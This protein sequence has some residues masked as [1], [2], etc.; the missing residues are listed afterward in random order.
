MAQNSLFRPFKIL[1]N[2]LNNL[3]INEGQFIITTDTRE[4]Y[5]DVSNNNRIF[6]G[7]AVDDID[8][9]IANYIKG[10]T[11][12]TIA[13]ADFQQ[14]GDYYVVTIQDN[15]IKAGNYV[16]FNVSEATYEIATEAEMQGFTVCDVGYFILK[17]K[18]RPTANITGNYTVIGGD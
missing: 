12:V 2:E 10:I 18:N 3:S 4:T 1:K 16:D 5:V 15:D 8:T 9:K 11:A 17:C 7:K 6:L 14:S 13:P